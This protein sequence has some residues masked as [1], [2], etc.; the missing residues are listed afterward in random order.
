MDQGVIS[1]IKP[2]SLRNALYKAADAIDRD[3]SDKSGQNKLKI[4]L[5]EY[6]SLNTIKNTHDSWQEVK[7]TTITGIWKK[8]IP[9]LMDDFEGSRK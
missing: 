6:T 3:S 8:L 9:T 4:F 1:T 7:T 2:Y 5:K